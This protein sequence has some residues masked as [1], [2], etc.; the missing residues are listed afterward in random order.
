MQNSSV[1]TENSMKGPQ[2]IKNR[3]T[4]NPAVPLMSVYAKEHKSES[5]RD[6]STPVFIAALFTKVKMWKQP[7]C[8]FTHEWVKK[9]GVY[10]QLNIIEP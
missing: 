6:I 10:T 5:Q 2:K 9:C 8:P 4:Y 1:A 3:T 7:K